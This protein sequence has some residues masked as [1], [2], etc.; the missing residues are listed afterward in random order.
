MGTSAFNDVVAART[1]A[2]A[3]IQSTPELLAQFIELGGL[4]R[5]L[6]VIIEEGRAAEDANLGQSVAGAAGVAATSSVNASFAA[7]QREYKTV[8][9]IVRAVRDDLEQ[10]GAPFEVIESVDQI[11]ANET[12][13]H[14]KT[15]KGEGDALVK[16]ALKKA[17]QEAVRAEIRKDA[18]ALLASA[19]VVQALAARRVDV[20]RLTKLRDEADALSGR[21]SARVADKAERKL[22]TAAESVAVKAQR[23]KWGAV[24]RILASLSDE[25]M[26]AVLKDA[27][28]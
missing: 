8:M 27:R 23:R 26:R 18:A 20:E 14:V 5:D 22:A 11:L 17:S 28:R 1:R 12:A 3:F 19:I 16:K 6:E 21:L 7:L 2:A 15:V 24:Y 25:R 4:A 10:S 9:A 13:V